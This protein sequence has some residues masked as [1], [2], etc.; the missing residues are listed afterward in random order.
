MGVLPEVLVEQI[1]RIVTDPSRL[2][3]KWHDGLIEAG[4]TPEKYVETL[5]CMATTIAVDTFC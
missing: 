2:T 4:L 3:R 5:G 1:H